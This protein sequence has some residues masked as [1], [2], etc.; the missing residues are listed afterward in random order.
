M[1]YTFSI[2]FLLIFSALSSQGLVR[3]TTLETQTA[4]S[5]NVLLL[6]GGTDVR[7]DYDV[8]LVAIEYETTGS[9]GE[10]DIASGL[11]IV[12]LETGKDLP[13]HA[14][15]HGT[16]T[17]DAVPSGRSGGYEIG[18]VY[19][20]KGHIVFMPDYIGMGTSRGFHPFVHRETEASAGLDMAFATMEYINTRDDINLTDQLTIAGYSQGGHAAMSFQQLV[21]NEYSGQFDLLASTP[22]SGPY[23]LSGAFKDFVFSDSEYFFP[24]YLLYQVIG[25]NTIDG[26]IYENLSEILKEPYVEPSE[27]FASSG[28]NLGL[29]H[30]E[31]IDLLIENEGTSV[32]SK[33]FN[34]QYVL[35]VQSDENHPYN[36]ALRENNTFNFLANAPT[37]I[38]YCK[39]DDQ[40]PYKSSLTADSVLNSLG[41]INT[42]SIDVNPEADHGGCIF[43]AVEESLRFIGEFFTSTSTF[44]IIDNQVSIN[45]FP[46]PSSSVINVHIE[47]E[48]PETFNINI[49]DFQ[50]RL[51][52]E[53]QSNGRNNREIDISELVSGTY[54]IEVQNTEGSAFHKF[55]KQ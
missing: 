38:I 8:E 32:P 18:L 15:F 49:Y 44:E 25:L 53:V 48:K 27:R 17:R 7:V 14:H 1:R 11:V 55:V 37:R 5:L 40:V 35:D 29:L 20:G 10:P 41:A 52:K 36:V 31:L 24:G 4:S 22:M 51:I 47:S 34:E 26:T 33:M 2:V 46:N 42:S 19:A 21:E 43:P 39:A 12:P 16:T 23:D 30:D 9:D 3:A 45:V 28:L 54:V 50:A 6:L 13:L